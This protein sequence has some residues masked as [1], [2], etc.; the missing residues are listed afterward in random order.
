MLGLGSLLVLFE[1]GERRWYQ[2]ASTVRQILVSLKELLLGRSLQF[3]HGLFHFNLVVAFKD[4]LVQ[5]WPLVKV[6]VVGFWLERCDE[7]LG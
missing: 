5:P 3:Q 2:H 4:V 6:I 1:A 7:L